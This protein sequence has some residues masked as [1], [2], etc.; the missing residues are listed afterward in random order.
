MVRCGEYKLYHLESGEQI[1]DLLCSFK[2]TAN[3]S[4]LVAGVIDC[5]IVVI[6]PNGNAVWIDTHMG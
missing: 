4:R 6:D 3:F 1:A 2:G 5:A